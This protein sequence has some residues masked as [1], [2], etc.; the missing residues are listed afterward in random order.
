M[1]LDSTAPQTGI[2]E[3]PGV[4]HDRAH[5]DD[6]SAGGSM[7]VKV[8]LWVGWALAAAFILGTMFLYLPGFMATSPD[9]DP[10]PPAPAV[11]PAPAAAPIAQPA[12]LPATPARAPAAEPA[13]A[14]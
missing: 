14:P 3:E 1:S 13:T 4:H 12:A 5:G 11:A 6:Y 7:G 9:T 2:R 8:F 10:L